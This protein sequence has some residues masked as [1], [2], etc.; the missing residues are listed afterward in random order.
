MSRHR[1]KLS[2]R[3]S[4]LAITALLALVLGLLANAAVRPALSKW[5]ESQAELTAAALEHAKLTRF[6]DLSSTVAAEYGAIADGVFRTESDQITMSR[7]LSRVESLARRPGMA[8]VSAKPQEVVTGAHHREY[9]IR[10]AVSGRLPVIV[11]FVSELLAGDR[12]IGVA[13]VSLSAARSGGEVECVLDLW[14][15]ALD[16]RIEQRTPIARGRS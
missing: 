12:A 10:L 16:K 1:I 9:P 8:I 6:V 14:L 4:V 15:V 7:F 2:P 11:E 5:R 13:S 3:E